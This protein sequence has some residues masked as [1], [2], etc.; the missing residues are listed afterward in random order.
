ML[1]TEQILTEMV[2][3]AMQEKAPQMFKELTAEG[4]LDRVAQDRADAALETMHQLRQQ[5]MDKVATSKEPD[6]SR[7]QMGFQMQR[8]AQQAAISQATEFEETTSPPQEV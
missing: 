1:L 3:Q 4:T 8:E 5:A 2:K 7:I 6:L